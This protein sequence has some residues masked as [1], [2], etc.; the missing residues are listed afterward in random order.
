VLLPKVSFTDA[1]L[2][3]FAC[4]SQSVPG[5]ALRSAVEKAATTLDVFAQLVKLLLTYTT[6]GAKNMEVSLAHTYVRCSLLRV[7]L[8]D[9][10]Q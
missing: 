10:K 2:E 4:I 3:S 7:A 9:S 6:K 5:S 8:A 1:S